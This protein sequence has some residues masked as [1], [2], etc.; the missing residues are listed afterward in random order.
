MNIVEVLEKELLHLEEVIGQCL[1]D[2]QAAPKGSI[3]I[4]HLR[5]LK[6]AYWLY[7]YEGKI[8]HLSTKKIENLKLLR[9]LLQKSY[10]SKVLNVA[11]E[12]KAIIERFLSTYN[13]NAISDVY[14]NL[15][16]DKKPYI[17]PFETLE[18]EEKHFDEEELRIMKEMRSLC[19]EFLKRK[20]T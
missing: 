4:H 6:N 14:E 17:K 1:K 11:M 16:K 12:Q 15:I 7:C 18:Q 20:A 10:A 9:K 3:R 19:D 13:S 2:I 5:R 8:T